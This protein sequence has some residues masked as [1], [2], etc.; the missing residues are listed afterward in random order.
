MI[1]KNKFEDDGFLI[2]RNFFSVTEDIVPLQDDI[3][4]IIH[5]LAGH[6]KVSYKKTGNWF[7]GYLSLSAQK[8]ELG[9]IVYDA[10]KQL[11]SFHRLIIKR[12][13]IQALTLLMG[14]GAWR[15]KKWLRNSN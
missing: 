6:H 13:V 8:R 12:E 15:C 4:R 7:D 1:D 14:G 10:V 5:L 2:V 11:A 3:Q 9:S